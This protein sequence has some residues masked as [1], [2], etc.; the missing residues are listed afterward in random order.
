[1]SLIPL[2]FKRAQPLTR[3]LTFEALS[4]REREWFFIYKRD[5]QVSPKEVRARM[6]LIFG[7]SRTT[8]LVGCFEVTA[9]PPRPGQWQRRWH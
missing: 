5:R 2:P 7:A 6:N 9:I 4:P 8:E 3:P 1:M